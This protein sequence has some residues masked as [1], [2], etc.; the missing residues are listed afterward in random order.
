[1]I[2]EL[3]PDMLVCQQ[4]TRRPQQF[5]HH[6]ALDDDAMPNLAEKLADL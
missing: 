5:P 2:A 3:A 4:Y 6:A 1:M